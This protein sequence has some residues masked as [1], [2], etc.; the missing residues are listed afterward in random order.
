M[1]KCY[2][3][4]L[5]IEKPEWR[6]ETLDNEV[7]K[8]EFS[9]PVCPICGQEVVE[10]FKCPHCGE[11]SS[12][13]NG[14]WCDKCKIEMEDKMYAVFSDMNKEEIKF[15]ESEIMPE[16]LLAYAFDKRII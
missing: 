14:E 16:G 10:I 11:M 13:S 1:H 9:W 7:D 15:I 2:E 8:I 4:N 6:T 3:C 5:E 12:D